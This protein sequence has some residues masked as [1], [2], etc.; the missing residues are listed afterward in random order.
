MDTFE[1][2]KAVMDALNDRRGAL[3]EQIQEF[4]SLQEEIQD[5]VK[6]SNHDVDARA[7]LDKLNQLFPEG[8]SSSQGSIMQKVAQIEDGFKELQ[9]GFLAIGESETSNKD[10]QTNIR[11]VKAMRKYM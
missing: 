1:D 10:E 3:T 6:R 8:M 9:Q 2:M 7:K 11:K 5:L 4:E